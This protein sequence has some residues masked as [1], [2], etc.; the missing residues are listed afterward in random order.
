MSSKPQRYAAINPSY[1]KLLHGGDYNPDQWFRT[2]EI[3][4]E[5]MRLM[6]LSHCNAMSVGI[7][8]WA[9]LEPEEGRFEFGWLDTI[10]DKLAAEGARA[11]LH[12]PGV[13]RRDRGHVGGGA[14]ADGQRG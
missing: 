8:S 13:D 11:V 5:D 7:F 4:D 12:V 6:N 3:W 2:P 10:M 9:A 14:G 1:P